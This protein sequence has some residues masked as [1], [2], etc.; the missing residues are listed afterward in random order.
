MKFLKKY[1]EWITL[2]QLSNNFEKNYLKF[3]IQKV[4][5]IVLK[6]INDNQEKII[7]LIVILYELSEFFFMQT[8]SWLK[9]YV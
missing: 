1:Y 3:K 2:I 4:I 8:R 7:E 9:Y 6:L 5:E